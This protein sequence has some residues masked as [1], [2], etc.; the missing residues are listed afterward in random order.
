[1]TNP[2]SSQNGSSSLV[3]EQVRTAEPVTVRSELKSKDS[4][5]DKIGGDL[6]GWNTTVITI[7]FFLHNLV[8]MPLSEMRF[9]HKIFSLLSPRITYE[10]MNE[11]FKN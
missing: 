10:A 1:M 11:F 8:P 5:M 2:S 7:L 6:S 9:V 3:Q 4:D